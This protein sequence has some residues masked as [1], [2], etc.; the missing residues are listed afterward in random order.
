MK[1]KP[2]SSTHEYPATLEELLNDQSGKYKHIQIIMHRENNYNLELGQEYLVVN[3]IGFG[4]YQLNDIQYND[5]V[6]LM[7]FTDP[8]SDD[9]AE[10]RLDVNN[11]HPEHFLIFWDDIRA[12]FNYENI[13]HDIN[14]DELLE[15][16]NL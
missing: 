6:I 4:V 1:T 9:P 12:M 7:K 13:L 14:E 16:E 11:E 10:I 2:Q 8:S 5:G 3:N 15:L